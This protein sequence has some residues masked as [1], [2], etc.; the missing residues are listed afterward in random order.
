MA[1]DN[2]GRVFVCM[3]CEWEYHENQ[4][5][6]EDDLPPGTRFEEIPDSFECPECCSVK[7]WFREK[8]SPD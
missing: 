5:M 3:T 1:S 4:G 6:P 8:N 2:T 7:Y